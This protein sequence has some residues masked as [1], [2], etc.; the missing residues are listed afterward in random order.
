MPILLQIFILFSA[1]NGNIKK[2]SIEKWK[3]EII[4]TEKEFAEMAQKG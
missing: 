4:Q 3:S 2:D 1:C